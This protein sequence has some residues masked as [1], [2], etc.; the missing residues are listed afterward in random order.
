MTPAQLRE[1]LSRL[2]LTQAEAGQAIGRSVEAMNAYANGRMTIPRIV[3]LALLGLEASSTSRP[4]RAS[5][6]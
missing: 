3:E 1:T 5:K 4:S 2:N 6:T